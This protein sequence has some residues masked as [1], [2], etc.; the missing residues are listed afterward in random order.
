MREV[1]PGTVAALPL[2]SVVA[3][4]LRQAG[5]GH[6]LSYDPVSGFRVQA[7]DASTELL[8]QLGL[9]PA[10]DGAAP[11]G[12]EL[13]AATMQRV[14]AWT[15]TPIALVADFASRLR[16]HRCPDRAGAR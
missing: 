8:S 7:G 11:A 15:G 16:P 9:V 10:S 2:I 5:Y 6:V 14:A 1:V 13:F 3:G 12:V 4:E